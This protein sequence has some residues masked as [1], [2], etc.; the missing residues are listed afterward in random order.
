MKSVISALLSAALLVSASAAALAADSGDTLAADTLYTLELV[1]GSDAGYELDRVPT[2]IEALVFSM[3]LAGLADEAVGC[4][5]GFP[6]TDIP[7]WANEYVSYAYE[8][9]LIEGIS[10]TEFGSDMPARDKD[11]LTLLLRVLGYSDSDGDFT[12]ATSGSAAVRL[13]VAQ[14][15]YS[16]FDRGDMFDCALAALTCRLNG[17]DITLI[18]SLVA[19]GDVD[20]AK[21]SALGLTG[22]RP[23]S[24]VQVAER[25]SSAVAMLEC[26][27]NS[28][29]LLN[30]TPSSNASGFFISEDGIL[31][32][33]YH[34]IDKAVYCSVTLESGEQFA[35][36]RVLYYDADIDVSVLKVSQTPIGGGEAVSFPYLNMMSSATTKVGDVVYALGNPL[37]LQSSISS[38]IISNN[39]R[40]TSQFV[41]PMIQNTASISQGSS[42]GALMN[43][44]GYVIGITSG[45]FTYGQDMYLAVPI[46]AVLEADLSGE[47]ITLAE[48]AAMDITASNS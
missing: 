24:A 41:M 40:E 27:A 8:N 29:Q 37:G 34:T 20:R 16:D 39:H 43:E 32:S 31:V 2:R 33:N 21:A 7:A 46:A 36:E 30:K 23:L 38:G 22:L 12:W 47:G 15:L 6:F 35:V 13:G 17:Q 28:V 3:R 19:S 26:Y 48:L 18:D 25:Y 10:D 44:Y 5:A 4:R 9:G 1:E 42:G 14:S 11:F 45:Y